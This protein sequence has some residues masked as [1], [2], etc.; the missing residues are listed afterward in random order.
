MATTKPTPEEIEAARQ[1]VAKADAEA[2]ATKRAQN[3][4]LIQP[5]LDVGLGSTEENSQ[6]REVIRVLREKAI[7][8][9]SIDRNLP[10]ILFVTATSL[11]NA[12]DKIRS[13]AAMNP[14]P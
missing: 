3:Q 9:Q 7:D 14:Q 12:D 2:E 11:E 4:Q 13:L 8:L 5:F 6:V 1:M 10:N